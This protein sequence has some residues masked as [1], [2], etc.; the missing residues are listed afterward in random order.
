VR[1]RVTSAPSAMLAHRLELDPRRVRL[2]PAG[3]IL[4]ERA[5]R[6]MGMA[7]RIAAGGVREGVILERLATSARPS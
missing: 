7:A 4:L 3:I 1:E 5:V 6:A 2:L